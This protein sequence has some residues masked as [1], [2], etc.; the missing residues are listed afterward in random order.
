M[1]LIVGPGGSGQTYF[2]EFLGRQGISTNASNDCDRQKHLS[3]PAGVDKGRKYKGCIFLFGHPYY[4]MMSHM[5]RSWSWL[6]CLKLG[7]P[8]SLT[9]K[10]SS[11]LD[12]LKTRTVQEGRDVFGIE[13]Q[14]NQWSGATLDC[15]LLFLDFADVLSSKETLDAFFGKTL[16]FSRFEVQPRSSYDVDPDLFPIYEELYQRM[17]NNLSDK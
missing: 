7:N 6:Q 9:K 17:R 14:F 1:Y 8:F 10:V 4:T 5:R 2:M 13:H 11:R 3:S 12:L 15:P 16:D